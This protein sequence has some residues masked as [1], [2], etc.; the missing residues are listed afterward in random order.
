MLA[1]FYVLNVLFFINLIL[2]DGI[3]DYVEHDTDTDPVM[4][5]NEN[6]VK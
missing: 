2:L 4:T 1:V 5:H 6:S 3:Q